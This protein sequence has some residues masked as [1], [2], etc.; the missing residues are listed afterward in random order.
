M[1]HTP[2]PWRLDSIKDAYRDVSSANG[3]WIGLARVPVQFTDEKDCAEGEA[4]ARLIAAAPELLQAV[5][6]LSRHQA[7]Q[8]THYA[9]RLE[10][11]VKEAEGQ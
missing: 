11:L 3:E 1:K 6:D 10:K 7:I 8:G 5:K 9:A 2:G 4:N